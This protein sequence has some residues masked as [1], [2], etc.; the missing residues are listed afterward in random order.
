MSIK[1]N[2]VLATVLSVFFL[3]SFTFFNKKVKL[4]SPNQKD[5][6]YVWLQKTGKDNDPKKVFTF[7]NKTLHVSGEDFGYVCTKKKY[8]N[9]KLTLEFKW[10]E[11]RYAPRDTVKRDAGVLYLVDNYDGD[12][13]WPRGI[14]FQIQEGDCGDFW[15]VDNATIVF[16][17]QVTKK[18]QWHQEVKLKD[19]EKPRGKW[20]KVE[21]IVNKGQITHRLNGELVNEGRDPSVKEGQILLQSE[22]AE[23]YYRNVVL[24]E[25]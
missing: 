25:L 8:G 2:W 21:I 19:A 15:M 23:V 24:E 22:G 10:G 13:I 20:N 9:F 4:F 18:E 7:E 11:K 3:S 1:R 12:K 16:K 17:G 5:E 6:W 14:E